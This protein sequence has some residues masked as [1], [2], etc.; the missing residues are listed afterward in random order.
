ML[1]TN[2][3]ERKTSTSLYLMKI[4]KET[5]KFI[6]LFSQWKNS[7]KTKD[8]DEVL[9]G[10]KADYKPQSEDVSERSKVEVNSEISAWLKDCN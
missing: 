10:P 9:L 7:V 3:T 5:I 8:Y 6:I 1:E 4:Q 2:Q